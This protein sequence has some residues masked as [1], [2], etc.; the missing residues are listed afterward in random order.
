MALPAEPLTSSGLP[1]SFL[2][3]SKRKAEESEWMELRE[4]V[5]GTGTASL[6]PPCLPTFL[7]DPCVRQALCY[8]AAVA[9]LWVKD[10]LL[11]SRFSVTNTSWTMLRFRPRAGLW[12]SRGVWEIH[13][14]QMCK[15]LPLI[16]RDMGNVRR[17]RDLVPWIAAVPRRGWVGY[18][19]CQGSF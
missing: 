12:W 5:K 18:C 10:V 3:R 11:P 19:M 9:L 7:R 6:R 8:S 1:F 13:E 14:D 4:E 17:I 15:Q 2:G 16:Q